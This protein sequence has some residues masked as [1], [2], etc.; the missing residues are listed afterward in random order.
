VRKARA[1]RFLWALIAAV[2]F[3]A[4]MPTDARA[5]F[6]PCSVTLT[7]INCTNSINLG[8]G[9]NPFTAPGAEN[10]TLLNT[11][12]GVAGTME[13]Y[14][15]AGNALSQNQGIIL[16]SPGVLA[17]SD[18][19]GN[20]TAINS[21]VSFVTQAD[22]VLNGNATAIN[23]STGAQF[24][25]V[26]GTGFLGASA[27]NGIALA[28]NSG[29][30]FGM[31]SETTG[32]GAAIVNNSG[33]TDFLASHTVGGGDATSFNSGTVVNASGFNMTVPGFPFP[34]GMLA[35]ADSPTGNATSIN[36]GTVNG[37]AFS[38]AILTVSDGGNATSVNYGSAA[39]II[40]I[41]GYNGGN[42]NSIAVNYGTVTSG[43]VLANSGYN[44]GFG[45]GDGNAVA[46]NSGRIYGGLAAFADGF[47][48]ATVTNAGLVDGTSTVDGGAISL[49][50]LDP[51]TPTTLNIL[52]GS[53]IIGFIGLNGPGIPGSGTQVNIF[54]GHDI[55]STL[56]FGDSGCGCFDGITATGSVVNVFGGA[57]F[58]IVGDTVS[59]LDPTSF[60][61]ADKN[62]ADFSHTISSMVTS[63]LNNP[64]P[65]SGGS[66]PIGFAPS[67]NVAVDMARDAFAGISSLNYA[68]SDRVL[69]SNPNVTAA[70]GTSV[71]AQGFAGQRIQDADAPTLRSVNN[72]Y[73]GM[74]GVDKTFRP[75][76]RLGG[77]LGAGS[78]KSTIDRNSGD[79][80]S[81]I[82]FG[83]L[84]G[85]YAMNRSFVDFALLGGHSSND[86][87]RNMANNLAP[88]GMET[89]VA[90]YNGWFISPEIAYGVKMPVGANLTLTPTARVRY[91]AAGF[92]G[93]QEIGS[94]T[95]LTVASRTSHNFEE[96]AEVT[97]TKTSDPNPAQRMQISGTLG[98]LAYQRAG[99]TTVNTILLGQNLPFVTPGK[100]DV[101]GGY[102]GV[103]FDWRHRNGVT[104]FGAAEYT[105]TTDSSRTA[106]AK[107]GVKVAF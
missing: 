31:F 28:Q 11:P 39:G 55:S 91:L 33:V 22:A 97:L 26:I 63:R 4:M 61:I 1:T 74:M 84:Y 78:I 24:G 76:L 44:L 12:T 2:S 86:L 29:F 72:F 70:D 7:D 98:V 34:V 35:W 53:R 3:V 68:S 88:G 80:A 87:R 103:G 82:V 105:A 49:G 15:H 40:S 106:T 51:F 92:G 69:F 99:D 75:G 16:F 107:G 57:P 46:F 56:I 67:G 83:G 101:F 32:T 64:A 66:T 50:Q 36:T 54:G 42:G 37:G 79:T 65:M 71:W 20:A 94:T 41:G 10:V 93:Y 89:A 52:P 9:P 104:V 96:R 77:L 48:S 73:G 58:V 6:V 60:A 43:G 100:N 59:V 90:S 13:A 18:A 62:I 30:A 23:T 95:N 5:Q 14:T 27:E 85:R 8:G 81:D 102:G 47:G 17:S 45:G 21:G 38:P 25:A 19:G